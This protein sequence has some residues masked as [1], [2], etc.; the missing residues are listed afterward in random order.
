MKRC[1]KPQQLASYQAG[2]CTKIPISQ[3]FR[4]NRHPRR[5]QTMRKGLPQP[6]LAGCFDI[7]YVTGSFFNLRTKRKAYRKLAVL[8]TSK[9]IAQS[10]QTVG[11]LTTP[12]N[13]NS[14]YRHILHPGSPLPSCPKKFCTKRFYPPGL[15]TLGYTGQG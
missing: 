1:V 12:T 13:K 6:S 9:H 3:V 5:T 14:C 11:E 4:C 8:E 7:S 15:V 10:E 2:D